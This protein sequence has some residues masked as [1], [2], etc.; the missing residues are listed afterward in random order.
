MF[1][2]RFDRDFPGF[3]IERAT[4]YK[5]ETTEATQKFIERVN[6]NQ[7]DEEKKKK[8]KTNRKHILKMPTPA[9][10]N[11]RALHIYLQERRHIY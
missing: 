10:M 9:P 2:F 11:R 7:D 5:R 6:E 4:A 8:K 1:R 3:F